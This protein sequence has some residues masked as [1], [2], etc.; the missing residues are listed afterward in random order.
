[1]DVW[2]GADEGG[3]IHLIDRFKIPI[4]GT[5]SNCVDESNSLTVQGHHGIGNLT[6][7]YFNLNTDPITSCKSGDAST[8]ST[9]SPII[10]SKIY[11]YLIPNISTGE[12]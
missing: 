2:D 9:N 4:P 3:H 5:V 11:A 7:A 6:L 8:F 12:C 1:M 10:D